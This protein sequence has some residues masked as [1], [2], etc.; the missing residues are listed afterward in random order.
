M[1]AIGY[2]YSSRKV[3]SF[4]ASENTGT[5]LPGKGYEA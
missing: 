1:Y 5:T 2:K 3:L 4:I